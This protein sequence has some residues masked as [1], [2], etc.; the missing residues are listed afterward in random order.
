MDWFCFKTIAAAYSPL[1][2]IR[3]YFVSH[4][5]HSAPDDLRPEAA[6]VDEGAFDA[7]AG[8]FFQMAAGL[9]QLD[10]AKLDLADA[11][12]LADQVVEGNAGGEKIATGVEMGEGELVF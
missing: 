2:T 6:A 9:A 7:G 12:R 11:E 3:H 4:P 10:A 1:S 8:Q 5:Q